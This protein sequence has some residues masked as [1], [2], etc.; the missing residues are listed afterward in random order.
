MKRQ[1]CHSPSSAIQ[2]SIAYHL[3]CS[4]RKVFDWAVGLKRAYSFGCVAAA[5]WLG[6]AVRT[7]P[8]QGAAEPE[9]T[10]NGRPPAT[11]TP[12]INQSIQS[13]YAERPQRV[14]TARYGALRDACGAT[15][16]ND[17]LP[18]EDSSAGSAG[19]NVKRKAAGWFSARFRL[20]I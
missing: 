3:Q 11:R 20:R 5:S 1:C 10:P 2:S 15:R 6:T 17:T 12:G 8:R 13:K 7:G 16:A 18:R 4:G 14:I 19:A 9:A